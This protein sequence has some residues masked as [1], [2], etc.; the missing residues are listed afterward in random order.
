[1]S[2][3][4]TGSNLVPVFSFVSDDWMNF[5]TSGL[6]LR[7]VPTFGDLDSDGDLDMIVGTETG[8]VHYY[9]NTGGA[10][11]MNFSTPPVLQ[12]QDDQ[13]SIINVSSFSTPS[14]FDLNNDGLLDLVIGSRMGGMF[15]Y[16]NNGNSSVPSF[17]LITNDLGSV[18]VST[19]FNPESYSVPQFIRH[20]DTLHLFVGN[21]EGSIH[22]YTDLENNLFH[23]GVFNQISSSY[24]GIN[25]SGFSAL[26][27]TQL[28]EDNAYHMFVGGDLG[29]IWSFKADPFSAPIVDDSLNLISF[30]EYTDWSVYPNPSESGVFMLDIVGENQVIYLEVYDM[31]GRLVKSKTPV[32]GLTTVDLSKN[33]RG[34]YVV[35]LISST[36]RLLGTKKIVK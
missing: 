17:E 26:F 10:G 7:V 15:Y 3:Y 36:G 23:G 18:D 31:V 9:E 33:E 34:M 35:R 14:L 22:Y 8:H 6:G 16:R 1:M 24:A 32:F 4:N 20:N 5:S 11:P 13:G 30:N 2:F 29:G 27:I 28:T 19:P 21:R 25:T 12:M